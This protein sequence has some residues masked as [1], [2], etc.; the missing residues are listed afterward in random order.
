MESNNW[1]ET[2][3]AS[4]IDLWNRFISFLPE[5]IGAAIVLFA[6]FLIAAFLGRFVENILRRARIDSALERAGIRRRFE[7]VG[8]GFQLSHVVGWIVKWFIIIL[9]LATVADILDWNQ[10]TQFLNEV[11]MYIPNVLI[12]I[13]I[14]TIGLMAGRLVHGIVERTARASMMLA[15]VSGILAALAKWAVIIFAIMASLNQLKIAANLIQILFAGLVFAIT[16]AVGLSFGLGGR[17][18]AKEFLDRYK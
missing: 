3:Y 4:S 13:V 5:I 8:L 16:L 11:V 15:G 7:E 18:K 1:Q 14:L 6:G 17:D 9:V 12:A 10:I 2:F